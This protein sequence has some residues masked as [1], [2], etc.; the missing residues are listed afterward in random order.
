MNLGPCSMSV[1][2][3]SGDGAKSGKMYFS[4][5]TAVYVRKVKNLPKAAKK[6]LVEL[7]EDY[8]DE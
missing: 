5:G 4:D 6:H 7:D 2:G 1:R 3:P 8:F